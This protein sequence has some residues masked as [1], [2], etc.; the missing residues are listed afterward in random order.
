MRDDGAEPAFARLLIENRLRAA[1]QGDVAQID[2]GAPNGSLAARRG[3]RFDEPFAA[4][5]MDAAEGPGVLVFAAAHARPGLQHAPPLLGRDKFVEP[6]SDQLTR[7]VSEDV[8]GRGGGKNDPP[9]GCNE[10]QGT[11]FAVRKIRQHTLRLRKIGVH[12]IDWR[13]L[14]HREVKDS[15]FACRRSLVAVRVSLVAHR[16]SWEQPS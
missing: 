10:T 16:V 15:F 8:A 3:A 11:S 5:L 12:E 14:S 2:D 1:A 6:A 4:I 13:R 7:V 9:V